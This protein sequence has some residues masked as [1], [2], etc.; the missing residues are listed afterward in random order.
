MMCSDF[1]F[2][3]GVISSLNTNVNKEIKKEMIKIGIDERYRLIPLARMATISLFFE[4]E[5]NV[6]KVAKR[7]AAGNIKDN[8]QGIRKRK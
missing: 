2:V 6:N 7:T 5:P 8:I 3:Y 1:A 4:R